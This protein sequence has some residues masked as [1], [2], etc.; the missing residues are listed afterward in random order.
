M[1]VR[2]PRPR[3]VALARWS[4]SQRSRVGSQRT[5]PERPASR[6]RTTATDRGCGMTVTRRPTRPSPR[7]EPRDVDPEFT[8]RVESWLTDAP[9]PADAPE[10]DPDVEGDTDER[11]DDDS[12]T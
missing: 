2:C 12:S 5:R 8:E 9:A 6:C 10:V 7:P 1:S 4:H 3:Q 11:D